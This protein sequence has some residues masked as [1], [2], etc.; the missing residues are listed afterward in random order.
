M[1][2]MVEEVMFGGPESTQHSCSLA[3]NVLGYICGG[4]TG[5]KSLITRKPEGRE[6]CL[7]T[8]PEAPFSNNSPLCF[9]HS[10]TK[11]MPVNPWRLRHKQMTASGDEGKGG[12]RSN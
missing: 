7:A 4:S 6:A 8:L 1:A 11:Q 5:E 12:H 10:E 3:E 9:Y 2:F